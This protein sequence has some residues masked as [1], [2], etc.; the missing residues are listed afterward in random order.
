MKKSKDLLRKNS[1]EIIFLIGIVTVLYQIIFE[2]SC[3]NP[4][5]DRFTIELY[6]TL[7]C[8]PDETMLFI[9]ASL[10][11]VGFLL[12]IKKYLPTTK[13]FKEK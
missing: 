11:V 1:S 10:S 6:P 5:R 3:Y 9:G 8:K 12:L 2:P 7:I 4:H 13:E